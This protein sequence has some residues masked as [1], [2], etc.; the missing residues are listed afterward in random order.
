MEEVAR[1]REEKRQQQQEA[2]Q[3]PMGYEAEMLNMRTTMVTNNC[4][5]NMIMDFLYDFSLHVTT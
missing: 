4:A 3:A 5:I 1:Q 2:Q